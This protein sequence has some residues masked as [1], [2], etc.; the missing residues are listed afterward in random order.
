MRFSIKVYGK[1][2]AQPRHKAASFGGKARLY[3]EAKH[4]VHGF[5]LELKAAAAD[6]MEGELAD[7][8]V[9]MK[10]VFLMP[11]PQ[12]MIW[13]KRPMPREPYT[14]KPDTD[15][16]VKAVKDALTGIVYR[17]DSLI[18]REESEKLYA[19]GDERPQTIIEL[20]W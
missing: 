19:A 5:K 12:R 9:T 14:A 11:R 6:L 13:K 1:P 16:L 3:L 18:W 15:N 17:D 8:P 20:D 7:C 10:C 2:I 4:P